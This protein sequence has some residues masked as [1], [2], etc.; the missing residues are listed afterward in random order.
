MDQV[1]L[2]LDNIRSAHNVGAIL[3]SA[4][5]FGVSEVICLGITPYPKQHNDP[6][7][8]HIANRAHEAIFKT[9]LGAESIL[10]TYHLSNFQEFVSQYNQPVVILEQSQ[11]AAKLPDFK[12]TAPFS[13]VIGNEVEG[14][15]TEIMNHGGQI[16]EIP[17]TNRKESINVATASG[18]ALYDF[19]T[20]LESSST[21]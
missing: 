5:A 18:I 15:S 19:Y 10:T 21:L 2:V 12:P 17:H 9:A 11:D 13:L 4:A 3:R 1:T 6:R 20:K 14:V 7:L 8:P 16:V